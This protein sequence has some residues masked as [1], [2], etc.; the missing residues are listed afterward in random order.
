MKSTDIWVLWRPALFR[1]G[2]LLL[3]ALLIG[4]L[5]DAVFP[6]LALA[7]ALALLWHLRHLFLL[8][9][10]LLNSG[11]TEPPKGRGIWSRIAEAVFARTRESQLRRQR[12]ASI[13]KEYRDAADAV[14]DGLLVMDGNNKVRWFNLGAADLLGLERRIDVGQPIDSLI[15]SRKIQEWLVVDEPDPDGML[16]PSPVNPSVWLQLRVFE[17]ARNLKMLIARDVTEMQRIDSMRKDFVANVSHELRTPL[18]V[19]SGYLETMHDEIGRDWLPV[20]TT[21]EQQSLRMKAIVEDLLTLS[22]LDS[23]SG[24][25]DERPVPI[26][27]MLRA[28]VAEA[29]MLSEGRHRIHLRLSTAVDLMGNAKDLRSA[30]M[31]LLSNAV[32]YT[33]ADG[34]IVV[35][36]RESAG[37]VEFSVRDNGTG[38]AARHLPRL[39]ERFYRVSTDRSRSTGGTGLGLAIVKHVLSLHGATLDILS[40]PGVGSE[41]ICRFPATR[42]RAPGN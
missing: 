8:D 38:I 12:L 5:I 37:A 21:M 6:A 9:R 7:L 2:G 18:T 22:R 27:P 34:E 14:T 40:E 41:F 25:E 15:R 19:I 30:F 13:L 11:L 20:I 23:A 16:T 42:A 32:R 24:L 29:E 1:L 35:E 26:E 28:L 10:W 3:V 39:T 4:L 36:W 17:A 31:N 33:P